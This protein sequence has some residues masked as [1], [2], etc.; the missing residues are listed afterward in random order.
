MDI[1]KIKKDFPIFQNNSEL[2]Y[3]DSTATSQKPKM[4]IDKLKEYYDNYNANIYR[5]VYDISEKATAEYE[6]TRS[7]V[8]KFI[9]AQSS[10]EVVF[11]RGTTESINLVMYSLG[12]EIVNK[13]DEVVTTMME[14]HSNFVP[15]Q[16]LCFG[17]GADFK[18]IDVTSDGYLSFI[19]NGKID[20]KEL[21]QIVTKKTKIF[22]ITYISNV[23]GTINPIK[24]IIEIVKKINPLTVVVVDAA[25]AA[26][27]IKLNVQDMGADFVAFSSH[28]MLG[29]T[30]VGV[31]WGKKE[32]LEKMQPFQYGGEMIQEVRIE[33]TIYK[34]AP[35]KF[36]AGT[37]NIADVI[38]FKEA[39]KCLEKI[40]MDAVR[41]HEE[42]LTAYALK[43]LKKE[44]GQQIT[45]TGP[46]NVKDRGGVIAFTF[47]TYHPHDIAQILN[48]EHVCV[49]AGNHCA[50]P[51]HTMLK[52]NATTR[53]SFYI[54][55]DLS[56]VD[57][58]VQALKK[59]S[60]ILG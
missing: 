54:Y 51:L 14:H 58:L 27:H 34:E 56:D 30:G 46:E 47:G 39:V 57:K 1:Q 55:N 16:Q 4:V 10:D 23:L 42:E 11:T 38:A 21:A 35:H 50:Q 19:K 28:K 36:E 15:W 45:I 7:I 29:P 40:G 13:G 25:Q 60:E 33:E 48:E 44:F 49:R 8:A 41:V 31:L 17:I 53:A 22:A 2:V 26:P 32:L 37:P 12:R 24:E 59:V 20:E 43:T 9:N 6:E 52:I 3:L 18:V 5:G